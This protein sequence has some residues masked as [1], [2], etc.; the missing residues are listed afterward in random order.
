MK[1][2]H[3]DHPD[4]V[5]NVLTRMIVDGRDIYLFDNC[6]WSPTEYYKPIPTETWRD[7]TGEVQY[8]DPA[9][10]YVS[11][12]GTIECLVNNRLQKVG[13]IEKGYRLRK[14][15]SVQLKN[16][17]PGDFASDIEAF[18]VEKRDA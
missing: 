13:R 17:H 14:V 10:V 5:R 2:V 9:N 12:P 6:E 8:S 1:V 11:E 4:I 7:V 15:T 16:M 3:A 18:I